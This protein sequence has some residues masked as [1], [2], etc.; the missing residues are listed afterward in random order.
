MPNKSNLKGTIE[1]FIEETCENIKT[2][3]AGRLVLCAL[4]GGVDSAVCNVASRGPVVDYGCVV[5]HFS[6]VER[7]A[8][9]LQCDNVQG[10]EN[11]QISS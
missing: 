6:P 10:I 7:L 2:E 9:Y 1:A 4:S 3:A 11:L 5:K 8:C